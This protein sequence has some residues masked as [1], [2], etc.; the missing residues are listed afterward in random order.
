MKE[1]GLRADAYGHA[2]KL[3][4]KLSPRELNDYIEDLLLTVAELTKVQKELFPELA[5]KAAKRDK[6]RE[7]REAKEEAER[8]EQLAAQ[9]GKG[10][11][12]KGGAGGKVN[13]RGKAK[14]KAPAAAKPAKAPEPEA[15]P[16]TTLKGA[17]KASDKAIAD[18]L[19]VIE[20]G[21]G[22]PPTPPADDSAEQ[23]EGD[24]V[25]NNGLSTAKAQSKTAAERRAQA[26]LN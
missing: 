13:G 2:A 15:P 24:T 11:P 6:A 20:G 23:T 17:V 18:T 25:L 7:K 8:K 21:G 14:D 16:P 19:K 5:L 10:D 9:N 12:A 22:K 1:A 3:V 4:A 26:G